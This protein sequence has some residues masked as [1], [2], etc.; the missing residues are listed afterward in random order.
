MR[1]QATAFDITVTVAPGMVLAPPAPVRLRLGARQTAGTAALAGAMVS[2]SIFLAGQPWLAGCQGLA[3]VPYLA[4]G[5]LLILASDLLLLPRIRN[6][7]LRQSAIMNGLMLGTGLTIL[8]SVMLNPSLAWPALFPVL[9]AVF[10]IPAAGPLNLG[11]ASR[12]S[13]DASTWRLLTIASL[14][15]AVMLLIFG[16][17]PLQDHVSC[18][19]RPS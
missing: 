11:L 15:L 10:S 17:L 2:L 1:T 19:W 13:M 14:A 12:I 3:T 18:Q 5:L 6:R 8:V 4:S 7:R 9:F 16:F